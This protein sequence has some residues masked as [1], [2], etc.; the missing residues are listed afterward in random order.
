MSSKIIK[1]LKRNF[2]SV[3]RWVNVHKTVVENQDLTSPE[4]SHILKELGFQLKNYDLLPKLTRFVNDELNQKDGYWE[5]L[6]LSYAN[7]VA[8]FLTWIDDNLD[9]Q[10]CIQLFTD[11]ALYRASDW[12]NP[13]IPYHHMWRTFRE[14]FAM[15]V[16][17]PKPSAA[18]FLG[19][20]KIRLRARYVLPTLF[21]HYTG[22]QLYSPVI[23]HFVH[24]FYRLSVD[25]GI[26]EISLL[27]SKNHWDAFES[28]GRRANRWFETLTRE[29]QIK[30]LKW[31]E[32]R[33]IGDNPV[34]GWNTPEDDFQRRLHAYQQW[35][36]E[37][38]NSH[39]E[40]L[41]FSDCVD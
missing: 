15:V 39:E 20:I 27:L 35:E 16:G 41:D 31:G 38:G 30:V 18:I 40:I 4:I 2:Y 24:I 36:I 9:L 5:R 26:Y 13:S 19:Q 22:F 23:E 7:A 3:I 6:K 33:I 17:E 14:S 29:E 37:K 32:K 25:I 1:F 8:D 10:T 12:D 21:N 28:S 11:P 34:F